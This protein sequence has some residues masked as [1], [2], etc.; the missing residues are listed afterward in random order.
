MSK[1][2]SFVTVKEIQLEELLREMADVLLC[3][4][5]TFMAF[6]QNGNAKIKTIQEVSK[7]MIAEINPI[8]EKYIEMTREG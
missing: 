6:Q 5:G 7:D 2:I 4:K 8:I 1:H 3:C